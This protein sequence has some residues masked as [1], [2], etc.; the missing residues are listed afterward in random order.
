M[1]ADD[2]NCLSWSW[3]LPSLGR[4]ASQQV[5]LPAT[6]QYREGAELVCVCEGGGALLGGHYMRPVV[7][8]TFPPETERKNLH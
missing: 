8:R 4:K 5:S 6:L 2:L 1:K 3:L 7:F